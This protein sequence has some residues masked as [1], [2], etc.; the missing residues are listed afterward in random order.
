MRRVLYIIGGALILLFAFSLFYNPKV[1]IVNYPSSGTDII[2]FGDSLVAGV[3]SSEG[4]GFVKMLS[5]DLGVPIVNLGVSGNTTEDALGRIEQLLM[6]KPKVVM[7]LLGG[8]D[9]LQKVPKEE[10]FENLDKI[11][12]KIQQLGGV[13]LLVGIEGHLVTSRDEQYFEKLVVGRGTAYVPDIL[14]GILGNPELMSDGLHP[15]DKGYR[16][17]TDRIEPI[18]SSLLKN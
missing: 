13:V 14:N 9:Y 11:I 15:N 16:I 3:G 18:L 4:G 8:N 10:T 5:K 6:Y 12:L 2:A 7:V 17:M 1:K